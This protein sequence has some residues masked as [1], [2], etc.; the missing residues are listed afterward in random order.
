MRS[1]VPAVVCLLG[2]LGAAVA[3]SIT[4]AQQEAIQDLAYVVAANEECGFAADENV[5]EA[6]SAEELAALIDALVSR[7]SAA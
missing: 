7:E 4:P 6:F 2:T 5:I 3:Q 1:I